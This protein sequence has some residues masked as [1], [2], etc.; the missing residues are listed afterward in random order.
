MTEFITTEGS[1]RYHTSQD[2]AAFRRGVLGNEVQ[3][4]AARPIQRMTA[5]EAARARQTPCQ[6]CLPTGQDAQ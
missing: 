6:E 2:C 1:S 4:I 3:G 5:D